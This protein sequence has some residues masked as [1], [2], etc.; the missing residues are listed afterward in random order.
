MVYLCVSFICEE[1]TMD[2]MYSFLHSYQSFD[3]S[4]DIYK[5]NINEVG[6]NRVQCIQRVHILQ[7][8]ISVVR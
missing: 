8:S 2:E 6:R 7:I 5:Q 3:I 4:N 1:I